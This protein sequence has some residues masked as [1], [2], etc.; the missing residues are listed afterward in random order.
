[1][2]TFKEA[3]IKE[4]PIIAIWFLVGAILPISI[5]ANPPEVL[6]FVD[7]AAKSGL[8]ARNGFGGRER[9]DF[10]VETT[11]NGVAIF[12]ADGDGDQDV[13]LLNGTT[14]GGPVAGAARL[15]ELYRNDGA[16]HLESVGKASGFI[17]EGWAQGVCAGDY[18]NDGKTDVFISYYGHNRLY[19]NAGGLRFS[20]VTAKAGLPVTG[21]RFGSGCTFLDYDRD[22]RLDLFVSNYVSLDL[23]KTPRPG[24]GEYC[25]WKEIPVMCGPRGLPLGQNVLYHQEANGTFR[26]VSLAAGITKPGGRYALQPVSADFDND[27]WPDIYVA[28]D[29]T[30]SLLF[31]NRGDG[32]F[33]ERGVEAGVAYNADGRLQAGM[34]VAVADFNND[35][36]LDIAKTNFSGDLTSLFLNED[37]KFFTDVSG[38]ARLGVRQLLG[39]GIAFFDADEDGWKDLLLVNGHVYPEV[40]TA[41]V[42]DKYRQET[43]FFRNL[44]NG[45]FED[46]TAKAGP[47]LQVPRPSRGLALGDLAGD[48]RPEAVILNMNDAPSLLK[49]TTPAGGRFLNL[50]LKGTKANRSA[51]G[52]RVTVAAGGRKWIDEVQSGASFY[53][54]SSFTLHFG[55][56]QAERADTVT[57]RWPGGGV[58]TWKEIPANSRCTLTEGN[59][60]PACKPYSAILAG[61]PQFQDSSA[62]QTSGSAGRVDGNTHVSA[63]R[64]ETN[65]RLAE[66]VRGYP[67]AGAAVEKYLSGDLAASAEA[68]LALPA[69]LRVLPFLGETVAVWPGLL[70]RMRE[71]AS[72]NPGSSE[73]AFYLGRALGLPES[74]P[75]LRRAA[76]LDPKETRALVELGRQY[77]NADMRGEAVAAYE[78][79]LR[80]DPEIKTAHFRL[81]GLYRALGNAEKSR[82]HLRLYQKR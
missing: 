30:A 76:M 4:K 39:W 52:A 29:M 75:L 80:R 58:E 42:G 26:D 81:A 57:V 82:E 45:K 36:F 63:E 71:I 66:L 54:Q 25:V 67:A 35:G 19:Q 74:I 41:Q 78:E 60:V 40:E 72:S 18:D 79:A 33:Q 9:K 65:A 2:A 16:G 14:L 32:T 38:P 12:D 20:E 50:D 28:C 5:A 13:L 44:G 27:G 61:G 48:G 21:T 7:I 73:A 77:A 69:D 59:A 64:A 22:G 47:A 68:L 70:A 53:S 55:L 31:R 34:G 46:L 49:N 10:I 17:T 8:V 62:F 23:A 3:N 24:K 51:I 37:G 6:S 56:G 1:M 43:L 11:G 15:P